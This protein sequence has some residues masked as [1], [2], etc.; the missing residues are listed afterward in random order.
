MPRELT[1]VER[2][3]L[4]ESFATLRTQRKRDEELQL[5]ASAFQ[6]PTLAKQFLQLI[7]AIDSRLS[8]VEW[9]LDT[10]LEESVV[11]ESGIEA[12]L[13]EGQGLTDEQLS[14]KVGNLLINKKQAEEQALPDSEFC[15]SAMVE[16]D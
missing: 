10:A 8:R 14:Q 16:E 7:T 4:E 6:H 2:I 3:E 12:A 5:I 13:I 9:Q 15:K 11:Y 1:E